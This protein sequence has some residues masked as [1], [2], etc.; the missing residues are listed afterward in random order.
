MWSSSK[1][2]TSENVK[3]RKKRR[4]RKQAVISQVFISP[5]NTLDAEPKI[6]P[7]VA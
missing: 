7:E 3:K 1:Y 5:E 6:D 4:T 2:L